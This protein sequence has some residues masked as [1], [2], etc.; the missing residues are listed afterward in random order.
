MAQTTPPVAAR[1]EQSLNH[2]SSC[3]EPKWQHRQVHL[4]RWR[5]GETRKGVSQEEPGCFVRLSLRN[6]LLLKGHNPCFINTVFNG[7]TLCLGILERLGLSCFNISGIGCVP[8][9]RLA[10]LSR[11]LPMLNLTFVGDSVAWEN[12]QRQWGSVP[13]SPRNQIIVGTGWR[14]WRSRRA[15]QHSSPGSHRPWPH[16]GTARASGCLPSE[17]SVESTSPKFSSVPHACSP[18]TREEEAGESGVQG[19]P[20]LHMELE[21]NLGYMRLGLKNRTDKQR[22]KQETTQAKAFQVEMG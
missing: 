15:R 5:G 10:G 18:S 11:C 22:I 2:L 16:N 19:Q 17:H 6:V 12:P 13:S 21:V 9:Q 8:P 7:E 3:H 4:C 14:R 20:Q 1:C